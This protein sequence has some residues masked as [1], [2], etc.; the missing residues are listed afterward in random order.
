MDKLHCKSACVPRGVE[1]FN[2]ERVGDLHSHIP[3]AET[4]ATNNTEH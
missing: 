3:E 1:N 4:T 2:P